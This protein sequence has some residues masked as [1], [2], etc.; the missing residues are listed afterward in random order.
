MLR[1]ICSLSVSSGL[2]LASFATIAAPIT[3]DSSNMVVIA[4]DASGGSVTSSDA[5][6]AYGSRSLLAVD[7]AISS[8]LDINWVDT[9]SGGLFDFDFNQSRDGTQYSYARNHNSAFNFTADSDTT[10]A[11]SGQFS[12]T[13]VTTSGSVYSFVYLRDVT[14]STYLYR[15][16]DQSV[17]TLNESLNVGIFGEGDYHNI[18]LG[19][20]SGNLIAGNQ[21]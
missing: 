21:Y 7:S 4:K 10:Y 16:L 19:S 13:D 3:I 18:S 6:T 9:G 5:N 14:N 1:L 20:A 17:N 15:D 8:A 11:L 2:L 12:V